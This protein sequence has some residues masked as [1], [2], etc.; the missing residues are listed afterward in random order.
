DDITCSPSIARAAIDYALARGAAIEGCLDGVRQG[1]VPGPCPDI[2]TQ[3][4]LAAAEQRKLAAISRCRFRPPGWDPCPPDASGSCA[5]R[6][7]SLSDVAA[8][9]DRGVD[10]LVDRLTCRDYPNA[11]A[12]G[13]ACPQ[14]SPATTTST[15]TIPGSTTTTM[16]PSSTTTTSRPS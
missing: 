15:T 3:A 13:I 16:A 11:A 12:D 4:L 9:V 1:Q 14:A 2:R 5:E 8:R 10:A 6:T 7:T